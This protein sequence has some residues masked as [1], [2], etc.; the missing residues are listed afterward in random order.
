LLNSIVLELCEAFLYTGFAKELWLELSERFGQNDG[1]LL[2]Q[3]QTKI[4]EIDQGNDSVAIY[5]T[6][7]KGLWDELDDLL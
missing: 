3:F 5:Y 2:Y 4:L 1:P 6:K 7:L